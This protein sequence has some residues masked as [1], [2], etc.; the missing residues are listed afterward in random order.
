[1]ASA[2]PRW[3]YSLTPSHTGSC[4]KAGLGDWGLGAQ[5]GHGL[6]P[7]CLLCFVRDFHGARLLQCKCA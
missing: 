5:G 7:V 2:L 1:M 4:Q 6:R 3:F